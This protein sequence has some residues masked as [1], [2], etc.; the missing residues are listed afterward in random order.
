MKNSLTHELELFKHWYNYFTPANKDQKKSPSF[1][2]AMRIAFHEGL[3]KSPESQYKREINEL[4][5]PDRYLPD[6]KAAYDA[7]LNTAP[8]NQKQS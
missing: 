5:V 4:N 1:V 6:L 2:Q 3:A 7:G 8:Q